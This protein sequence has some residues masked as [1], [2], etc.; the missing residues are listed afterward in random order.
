MCVG[1]GG[2]GGLTLNDSGIYQVQLRILSAIG[3]EM[4]G[5]EGGGGGGFDSLQYVRVHMYEIKKIKTR[6]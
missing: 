4:R 1:G 3:K 5:R 6:G 2:G